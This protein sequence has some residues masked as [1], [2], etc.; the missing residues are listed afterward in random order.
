[1]SDDILVAR[2]GFSAVSRKGEHV[3]VKPGETARVGHW[4]VSLN[5]QLWKPLDVTYELPRPAVP[6]RR[7]GADGDSGDSA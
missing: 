5:P 3:R 2:S 6:K 4:V 1:M 7:P